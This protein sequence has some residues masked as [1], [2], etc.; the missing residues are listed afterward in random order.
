[1]NYRNEPVLAAC[2]PRQA[3]RPSRRSSRLRVRVADRSRDTSSMSSPRPARRSTR[4]DR[5]QVSALRRPAQP[6]RRRPPAAST[7]RRSLHTADASLRQRQR[8]GARPGRRDTIAHSFQIQGVRWSYEPHDPE[9]GF[10]NAQAMG[11]SEHFEMLFKLRPRGRITRTARVRSSPSPTTWCRPARAWTGWP[12]AT[13]ASCGPSISRSAMHHL[14]RRIWRCSRTTR[15]TSWPPRGRPSRTS[16][17]RY[18]RIS[19]GSAGH[20]ESQVPANYRSIDVT[21]TT[22]FKALPGAAGLQSPVLGLRQPQ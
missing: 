1:M 16:L 18:V 22:A 7:S 17:R 6:A 9:S 5:L 13:G 11:I 2:H 4:P 14:G 20:R 12:T 10:K 19:R 3:T 8:P 21:A 15:P